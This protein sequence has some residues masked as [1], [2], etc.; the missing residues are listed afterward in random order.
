MSKQ[1]LTSQEKDNLIKILKEV[2]EA[3]DQLLDK[4]TSDL[5]FAHK[6]IRNREFIIE[7]IK[8]LVSDETQNKYM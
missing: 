5:V 6:Q 8:E 4:L 3:K 1:E 2:N 7:K